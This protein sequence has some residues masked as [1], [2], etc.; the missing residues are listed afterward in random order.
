MV[1][2]LDGYA[3]NVI[4]DI[5]RVLNNSA[6]ISKFTKSLTS[7]YSGLLGGIPKH[8]NFYFVLIETYGKK[9]PRWF[10]EKYTEY[11]N[12]S[13]WKQSL[14]HDIEQP[15]NEIYN[16]VNDESLKYIDIFTTRCLRK[17]SK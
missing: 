8:D 17:C 4:F 9:V 3:E 7:K 1:Q 14:C 16:L 5:C 6:D 11:N 12:D 10:F 13:E 2:Q 15:C